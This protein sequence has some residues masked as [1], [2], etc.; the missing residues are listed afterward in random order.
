[1]SSFGKLWKEQLGDYLANNLKKNIATDN[2]DIIAFE[3]IT[4]WLI[5]VPEVPNHPIEKIEVIS[6][7]PTKIQ[8]RVRTKTEGVHYFLVTVTEQM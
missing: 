8:L 6:I 5:K 3:R 2:K 1:M 7:T 4:P